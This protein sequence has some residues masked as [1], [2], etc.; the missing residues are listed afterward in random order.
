VQPL[1]IETAV[2][3]SYPAPE[4][5]VTAVMQ[6]LANLF[7]AAVFPLIV[8]CRNPV[9]KSMQP[10]LW[11]I[12]FC[13]V[14]TGLFYGTFDGNYRRL[15][16]ESLKEKQHRDLHKRLHEEAHRKR[17]AAVRKQKQEL[18]AKLNQSAKA[19]ADAAEAAATQPDS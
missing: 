7:S 18:I 6:M 3:V 15:A 12:L 10:A 13:L 8:L 11:L 9:T 4:S 2:E 1:A 16:H 14:G 19:Q 5:S 17:V